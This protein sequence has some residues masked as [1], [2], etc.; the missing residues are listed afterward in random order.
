MSV[1]H[2]PGSLTAGGDAR[3][4]HLAE[5]GEPSESP[6][7]PSIPDIYGENR[8]VFLVRDPETLYAAWEVTP[9]TVDELRHRLQ[10]EH[11]AA[12]LTLRVLECT[13]PTERNVVAEFDVDGAHDWY[14]KHNRAGFFCLAELGMRCGEDYIPIVQSAPVNI[15][16]GRE[17][18]QIDSDWATIEEVLERSRQ[19]HYRTTSSHFF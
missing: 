8:L 11:E 16:S 3:E 6:P 19:G 18:E 14:I 10:R 9:N 13:G 12:R 7:S 17:S 15:P 5:P 4:I 1:E 2:P